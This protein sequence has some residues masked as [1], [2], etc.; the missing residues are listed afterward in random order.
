MDTDATPRDDG[1]PGALTKQHQDIPFL[2]LGER[3]TAI[4]GA[5]LQAIASSPY[6]GII[7]TVRIEP[8]A[9][10]SVLEQAS[11]PAVPIADFASNQELR[12]DFVGTRFD[13]A[14]FQE[15]KQSFTPVWRRLEE[16]PFR[17]TRDDRAD[18]TVLRLAYSRD[19]PIEAHYS[20]DL[21]QAVHYP[22]LGSGVGVRR[23]LEFLAS[24]DLLR[25]R[26]FTRTHSC[27]RCGSARLNAYEACPGCGGADVLDETIV[28]HY[29][30]GWQ[31]PESQFVQGPILVCPKCRRE[32]RHLGIDYG[33]PGNV[34]VCRQC[35]A[36]NAEPAVRF[37]CLD[38]AWVTTAAEAATTDW[39]HYDLTAHAMEALREGRLP[40]F[41]IGPL[42]DGRARACSPLEFRLLTREAVRVAQ[43]Y[44]R[45]F[46][47]ARLSITNVEAL[48]GEL[49]P[50][51]LSAAFQLA[52]EAIVDALRAADFVS[53]DS[54]TSV[55]I[56]FPET[57]AKDVA[58]VLERILETIR[59][60]V[61]A[62]LDISSA[63]AEGDAISELVKES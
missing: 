45:A 48:R 4:S 19:T 42:L 20:P 54:A 21:H 10:A 62:N 26:H 14:S 32:L 50:M 55:V 35:G 41:E 29:R 39:Y 63:V 37:A 34:L 27:G 24:M 28:H 59:K 3:P 61:A 7:L 30:C 18:L 23:R 8:V 31:A 1:A 2:V 11:D 5:N 56:G 25:R 40:R 46:T 17:S 51:Q 15:L 49:G 60:T 52:V 57:A 22:L 38:C 58:V 9:L 6:A 12:R 13:L 43:R 53:A 47:V 16:I 33:K 44:K 36:A